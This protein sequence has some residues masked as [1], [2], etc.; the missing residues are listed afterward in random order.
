MSGAVTDVLCVAAWVLWRTGPVCVEADCTRASGRERHEWR[1]RGRR[2][3]G[4]VGARMR[5]RHWAR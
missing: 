5:E 3:R 1:T 4:R 2:Q